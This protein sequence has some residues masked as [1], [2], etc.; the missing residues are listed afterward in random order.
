MNYKKEITK[1]KEKLARYR[2]LSYQNDLTGLWNRRKLKQDVKR[3][4][5]LKE[6]FGIKFLLMMIDLDKFK[7]VNDTQGHKAGDTLLK[8]VAKI[9]KQN[10]RDYEQAYHISGDEFVLIISHYKNHDTIKR[11]IKHS[12][13]KIGVK[14]SVGICDIDKKGCLTKADRQMYKDKRGE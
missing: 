2:R 4:K 1:L 14:A 10:I 5:S 9:L 6:R 12:L 13:E 3:Y 8:C 11:R 7:E